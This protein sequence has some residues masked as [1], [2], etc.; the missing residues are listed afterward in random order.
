MAGHVPFLTALAA[1][2]VSWRDGTGREKYCAVRGGLLTVRGGQEIAIAT[3][4][5]FL[6]DDLSQLEQNLR[7][8]IAAADERERTERVA[9]AQMQAMAIRRIMSILRPGSG[10]PSPVGAP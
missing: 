4:Q 10:G 7:D 2:V 3:R 9:A 6:G 5:A 8:S 1:S